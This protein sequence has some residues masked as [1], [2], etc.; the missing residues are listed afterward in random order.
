MGTSASGVLACADL[1]AVVYVDHVPDGLAA[2]LPG[3]YGSVFCTEGWF[4]IFDDKT[5]TGACVLEHPRHVLLYALEDDTIEVLNKAFAMAPDDAARACRA[6]FR[7]LPAA[8][9]IHLEVLFPPAELGLPLRVLYSADDQV[10]DLPSSPEEYYRS[11]GKRTRKNVRNFANRL[12]RAHP[13]ARAERFVVGDRADEL[14]DIFLGW[15]L[16]RCRSLGIVSGYQ[17]KPRQ[18]AQTTLLIERYGE[19]QATFIDDEIAAL[20][21]LFLFGDQATVYAGA[22]DPKY[23][24]LDLG[25]LSTYRAVRDTI[26]RGA[27][28]CHLLWGTDFYKGLLGARPETATRLSVFRSQTARFHSLREAGEARLHGLR[29]PS[30]QYWRARRAAGQA[31]RRLSPGARTDAD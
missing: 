28:R 2:E 6:L 20:E 10:I 21:F 14:F 12:R 22:F 1:E 3:L 29:S 8:R 26:G 31:V 30:A 23:G 4:R 7:A 11:L 16:D 24:D 27:R 15:H 17:K 18:A 5:A 19:A 13:D 25:F 9:R